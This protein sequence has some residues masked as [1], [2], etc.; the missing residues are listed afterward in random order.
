MILTGTKTGTA[1]VE[2][3][4]KLDGI[5]DYGYLHVEAEI[6]VGYFLFIRTHLN[7]FFQGPDV[8]VDPTTL[9]FGLIE[10]GETVDRIIKIKNLSPII[11][12]CQVKEIKQVNKMPISY[13]LTCCMYNT[14][15]YLG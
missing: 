7:V 13:N 1:K 14:F 12:K 15:F 11:A 2:L 10:Y 5:D 8:E 4:F 3:P 6:I 9:D